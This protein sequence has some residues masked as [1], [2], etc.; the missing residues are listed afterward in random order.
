MIKHLS[1][2]ISVG[3]EKPFSLLHISDTHLT[4]AN[5]RDDARKLELAQRRARVFPHAEEM[6][7][8]V[9]AEAKKKG[10]PIVHSGDLTDFVSCANIDAARKF[11]DS[12][13]V[14]FAAGNHEFSLYVGEAF[15]DA[16]Y[17]NKSLATVQSAFKNDIRFSSRVIN[18]VN[19]VAVDDSYYRFEP[20]QLEKLKAEVSRGLP[21]VLLMHTPLYTPELYRT[22]RFE[23]G[24]KSGCLVNVPPEKMTDYEPY[25]I[26]QQSADE[27]TREAC[28]YIVS[29]PEIRAIIAGHVHFDGEFSIHPGLTQYLTGTTT[30]RE[31][32]IV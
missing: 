2:A 19:L 14:F 8:E 31:I 27:I 12:H 11:T 9:S 5:D 32:T 16:A 10:L 25:R 6:L 28:E 23:R 22:I 4:L 26:R 20:E 21:I 1:T 13:D 7:R 17:R 30:I 29:T 3:A 18:G 24:N 15:E